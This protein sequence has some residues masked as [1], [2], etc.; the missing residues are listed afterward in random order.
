MRYK[1][2]AIGQLPIININKIGYSADIP[3]TTF[4]PARRDYYLICYVLS[5]KG[6]YNGTPLGKGEG[7]VVTPDTT[8]HIYPTPDDPWEILWFVSVDSK[9][10]ELLPYY[11]CNESFIFRHNSP[12]ELSE[13]KALAIS[14]NRRTINDA[15]MLELFFSVFKYHA[16]QESD[17]SEEETAA[18][19]YLSFS[20]NYI[21]NNY[22]KKITV[23]NL[24]KLLGI[25]QPY[26]YKIFKEAFNKSPKSFITDYRISMAKE[27]LSENDY[28][29][30][31]IAS[32]VGF[33][34]SFA[35]SKCFSAKT[36]MPPT[37]Y[38]MLQNNSSV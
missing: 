14:H 27:L 18:D 30:A 36:G 1:L 32:L 21:K 24:T 17:L 7:F 2:Y 11:N 13:I 31:Q 22:P 37:E 4:G 8:E 9:M 5:G 23:S 35:F 29:V 19:K 26:L 28:S 3:D 6:V 12:A 16:N 25:S 34:D 38:K 20:V 15:K 33:S 10:A